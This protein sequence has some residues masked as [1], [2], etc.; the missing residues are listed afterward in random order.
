MTEPNPDQETNLSPHAR[1]ES[2]HAQRQQ[3]QQI[4][5]QAFQNRKN[6]KKILHYTI[7]IIVLLLIGWLVFRA[8]KVEPPYTQGQVHWHAKLVME[9]CGKS[10]DL[11]RVPAGKSHLG[12]GLLHNHDDN[13]IHVEGQVIKQS[14]ITLGKFM[15]SIRVPFSDTQLFNFKTGTNCPNS[16]SPS[17]IRM[18]VNNK[19]STEFRDYI[20]QPAED[21]EQ[22]II[23]LVFGPES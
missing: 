2:E 18:F 16:T 11:P 21:A 1:K 6:K 3:E 10:L 8:I 5:E 4:K 14:E 20:I 12:T 15:D 19:S 13:I 17:I 23:Q 9:A 22:Q 7:G